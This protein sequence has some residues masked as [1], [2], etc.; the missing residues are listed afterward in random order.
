M[1]SKQPLFYFWNMCI[2]LESLLMKFLPSQREGVYS[3]YV[4]SLAEIIPWMFTFERSHYARWLSVH[5]HELS[6]MQSISPNTY[7]EFVKGHFVTQ[8]S[9]HK[10]SKLAHDQVHEQLNAMVKGDGGVIGITENESS[11]RRWMVAGP[12]IAQLLID[13]RQKREKGEKT[14]DRHHEQTPATQRKFV[15]DVTNVIS[16][17][18]GY[19]NPFLEDSGDLLT[20]HTKVVMPEEV[21]IDMK[22]AKEKGESQ[23]KAFVE[24]SKKNFYAP[25]KKNSCSLFAEKIQK[26]RGSKSAK[27]STMK[28]DINLFSRMYI[29]CQSRAGDMEKFFR[30]ENHRWPPALAHNGNMRGSENKSDI[31][32]KLEPFASKVDDVLG[33]EMKAIDGSTLTHS[34]DPRRETERFF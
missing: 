29:A 12:E 32:M 20:L 17:I 34:L 11:F 31:L 30:H 2:K 26:K 18:K 25:I 19:G 33:V 16:I 1:E 9:S 4:D 8:K 14:N 6:N 5:L 28:S 15:S 13:Y 10:F 7:E 22:T 24:R 27:I 3:A 23:Y 21:V